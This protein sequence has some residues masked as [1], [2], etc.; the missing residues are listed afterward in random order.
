MVISVSFSL[1]LDWVAAL[2][3]DFERNFPAL[4]SVS[5]LQNPS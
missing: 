3:M 4:N 2:L 5:L 1:S